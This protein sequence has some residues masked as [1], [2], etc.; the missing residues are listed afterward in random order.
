MNVQIQHNIIILKMELRKLYQI[1]MKHINIKE[2]HNIQ[3]NVYKIVMMLIL[4]M[5]RIIYV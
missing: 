2:I 5:Y 3:Y 1:V 4:I